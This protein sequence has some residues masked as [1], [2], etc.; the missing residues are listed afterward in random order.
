MIER[1]YPQLGDIKTGVSWEKYIWAACKSC[2]KE[3]WTRLKNNKQMYLHCRSCGVKGTAANYN[4]AG[5][6]RWNGGISLDMVAYRRNWKSSN[7]DKVCLYFHN[8]RIK[9]SIINDLTSEQWESIKKEH[10]FRCANCKRTEPEIQLTI[11]H[12]IPI[13]KGG[14]NTKSNV[15]PLCLSCNLRKFTKILR[16]SPQVK[17]QLVMVE[18]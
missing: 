3:R 15:Q 12:I 13:S 7:R 5:N 14:G 16:F 2:G 4:G 6:P 1:E 8:R 9:G 18:I 11:D 10:R 17:N